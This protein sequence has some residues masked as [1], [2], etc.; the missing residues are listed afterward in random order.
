MS[1]VYHGDE[2]EKTRRVAQKHDFTKVQYYPKKLRKD[3]HMY[4]LGHH[5]CACD[6]SLL[7][8]RRWFGLCVGFASAVSLLL[9]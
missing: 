4:E 1:D 7:F 5:V 9:H 6:L 3:H 2:S 8:T